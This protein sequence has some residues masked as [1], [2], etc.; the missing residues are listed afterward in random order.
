MIV[1]LAGIGIA[2]RLGASDRLGE[3]SGPFGRGEDAP[4]AQRQHHRE[5]LRFPG[6]AKNGVAL[7]PRETRRRFACPALALRLGRGHARSR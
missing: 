6:F 7:V 2:G 1:G 3:R 5:S 4:F